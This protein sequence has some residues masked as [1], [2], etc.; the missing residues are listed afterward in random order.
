MEYL[1]QVKSDKFSAEA[2]VTPGSS[3]LKVNGSEIDLLPLTAIGKTTMTH[4]SGSVKFSVY[5]S[6]SQGPIHWSPTKNPESVECG[7][8]Q[9]MSVDTF[10][11]RPVFIWFFK[12]HASICQLQTIKNSFLVV[13]A[14]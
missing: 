13:F 4:D 12:C 7:P 2:A 9:K 14:K 8:N 1:I 6:F 5:E 3:K 10:Q 11:V